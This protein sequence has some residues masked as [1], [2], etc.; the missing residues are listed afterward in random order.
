MSLASAIPRA[1]F[2]AVL[3]ATSPWTKLD[4]PRV[5]T[6]NF[7]SGRDHEFGDLVPALILKIGAAFSQFS[8]QEI[9]HRQRG[10]AYTFLIL[11]FPRG[12]FCNNIGTKRTSRSRPSMSAHGARPNLHRTFR[13][14]FFFAHDLSEE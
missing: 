9:T 4:D 14:L 6:L 11:Q 10:P 8:H 3:F 2:A 12:D 1:V 13:P 7:V 5:K